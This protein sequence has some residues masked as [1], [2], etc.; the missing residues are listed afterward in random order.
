MSSPDIASQSILNKAHKDK[1]LLSLS[2]PKCLQSLDKNGV[3]YAHHKS[4]N[5]V[6]PERLQY[7][8]FGAIVPNISIPAQTLGKYGQNLKISTHSREAYEDVEVNFTVDNQF[9]NYWYIYKWLDILNDDRTSIYDENRAGTSNLPIQEYQGFDS[10][11]KFLDNSPT[12]VATPK[13]LEDYQTDIVLTGLNEYNNE[14]INFKYHMAFPVRLGG[15]DYTYR[16]STEITSSF[17]FSF[18][19]LTVE[20]LNG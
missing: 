5:S 6:M 17:T 1:F 4:D 19:Q 13:L 8:V 3:R 14:V 2:T 9:N 10:D 7:S 15:I 20:L 11:E 16:D 18:S 12:D